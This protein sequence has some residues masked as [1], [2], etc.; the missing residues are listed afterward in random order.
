MKRMKKLMAALL[1]VIVLAGCSPKYDY[2]FLATGSNNMS[3]ITCS[4]GILEEPF[5]MGGNSINE[6]CAAMNMIRQVVVATKDEIP[7][8]TGYELL[9]YTRQGHTTMHIAKPYIDI[10]GNWYRLDSEE[11][12]Y[13]LDM[14]INVIERQNSYVMP[15]NTS[16]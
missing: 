3:T 13:Y 7:E 2:T 15:E 9:V 11:D 10:G 1:A 5:N 12:L 14:M 8:D 4:G 6:F 16:N